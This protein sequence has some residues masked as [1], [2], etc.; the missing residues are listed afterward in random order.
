MQQYILFAVGTNIN[1]LCV[2]V[3]VVVSESSVNK[4]FHRSLKCFEI[5][6]R[7]QGP[8]TAGG[9]FEPCMSTALICKSKLD[10]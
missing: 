4:H 8:R 6:N 2:S 9:Y 10:V 5:K 7:R 3:R 1:K